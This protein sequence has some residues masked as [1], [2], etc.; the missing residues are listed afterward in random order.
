MSTN[1][2][3]IVGVN[4]NMVTVEF[5]APVHPERGGLCQSRRRAV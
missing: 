4:G 2:G 1:S 3:R 5:E